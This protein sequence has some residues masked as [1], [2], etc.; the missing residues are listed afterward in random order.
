MA[1]LAQMAQTAACNRHHSVDQQLCRR[2][3]L[4]LDR[5]LYFVNPK[6]PKKSSKST[7]QRVGTFA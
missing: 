3:L 4:S 7:H 2:L 6:Y 1:L 5:L